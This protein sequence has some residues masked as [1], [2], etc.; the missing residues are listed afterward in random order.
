ML[1]AIS[2]KLS[3][4]VLMQEGNYRSISTFLFLIELDPSF[5]IHLRVL[6]HGTLK[7]TLFQMKVE[8]KKFDFEKVIT[9]S[10]FVYCPLQ[11]ILVH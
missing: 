5:K 8:L 10:H 7:H 2:R 1:C 3:Y 9:L 11:D 6:K 4:K